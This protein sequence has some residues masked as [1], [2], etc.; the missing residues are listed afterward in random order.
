MILLPLLG[1][2]HGA[3]SDRVPVVAVGKEAHA[4][5][6]AEVADDTALGWIDENGGH[7]IV[8]DAAGKPTMSARS[9]GPAV[10]LVVLGDAESWVAVTRTSQWASHGA[11]QVEATRTNAKGH[12]LEHRVLIPDAC[13][14]EA[15][16]L[17]A[18]LRDGTLFVAATTA[19]PPGAPAR[20]LRVARWAPA[21]AIPESLDAVY[22]EP[23]L[24]ID[25]LTTNPEGLDLFWSAGADH[26]KSTLDA[27]GV[28]R[29]PVRHSATPFVP[30]TRDS[31][32]WVA[33]PGGKGA[34]VS[35]ATLW[36]RGCDAG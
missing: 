27:S 30:A 11:C 8:V 28:A 18:A 4:V 12:R 9:L 34:S 32:D 21:P 6:M 10:E 16:A 3:C 20:D 22:R 17:A 26:R 33:A 5:A 13:P 35:D 31:V 24:R 1:Y 2:A 29:G 14:M 36:F 7:L 15:P 19:D 25:G 23:D